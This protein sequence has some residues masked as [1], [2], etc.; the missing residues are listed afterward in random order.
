MD[1]DD[2]DDHLIEDLNVCIACEEA[3]KELLLCKLENWQKILKP[4]MIMIF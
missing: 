4:L 3:K 1:V 2:L